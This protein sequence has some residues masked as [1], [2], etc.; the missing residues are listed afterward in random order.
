MVLLS[1]KRKSRFREPKDLPRS[2]SQCWQRGGRNSGLA[3]SP[4]TSILSHFLSGITEQQVIL[5]LMSFQI[6]QSSYCPLVAGLP[7]PPESLIQQ[8]R[9]EPPEFLGDADAAGPTMTLLRTSH[10]ETGFDAFESKGSVCLSVLSQQWC[11]PVMT[12]TKL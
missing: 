4:G 12:E 2:H 1:Q 10:I 9:V 8:V 7:H 11:F 6:T 3:Q 5:K